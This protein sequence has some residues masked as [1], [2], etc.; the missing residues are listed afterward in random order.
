MGGEGRVL[1]RAGRAELLSPP[2][3]PPPAPPPHMAMSRMVKRNF[4]FRTSACCRWMGMASAPA[5]AP[6]AAAVADAATDGGGPP[7][8]P[9]PPD[10]LPAAEEEAGREAAAADAALLPP[11]PPPVMEPLLLPRTTAAPL[12][13]LPP[14]VGAM[15]EAVPSRNEDGR[16]S[17]PPAPAPLPPP[18]PRDADPPGAGPPATLRD[19][20]MPAA[21]TAAGAEPRPLPIADAP[22]PVPEPSD[23]IPPRDAADKLTGGGC[24]DGA[25]PPETPPL[26]LPRLEAGAWMADVPADRA[27]EPVEVMGPLAV[28]ARFR[29][30]PL[31][32]NM[33]VDAEESAR[34]HA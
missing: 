12:P 3:T 7:A 34:C 33:T 5:G 16:E 31:V 22:N 18:M 24:E 29:P 4:S 13:L 17:P 20:G 26:L 30:P 23:V 8:P 25:P 9:P 6:N 14:P 32:P 21:C 1:V 11:G 10:D 27:D 28:P 2:I 19:V 15:I